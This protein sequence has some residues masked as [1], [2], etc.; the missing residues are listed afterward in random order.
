MASSTLWRTPLPSAHL[1]NRLRNGIVPNKRINFFI[2]YSI[3]VQDKSRKLETDPSQAQASTDREKHYG[4]IC[5]MR[6]IVDRFL[7]KLYGEDK[8][9]VKKVI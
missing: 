5:T 2:P 7:L 3:Q 1:L 4:N 9:Q 8:E 6:I